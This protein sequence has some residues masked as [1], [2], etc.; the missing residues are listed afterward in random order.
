MVQ[1]GVMN[2]QPIHPHTWHLPWAPKRRPSRRRGAAACLQRHDQWCWHACGDASKRRKN[3]PAARPTRCST[4]TAQTLRFV[5]AICSERGPSVPLRQRGSTHETP[6]YHEVLTVVE[7]PDIL[8][9]VFANK[10]GWIFQPRVSS[11]SVRSR[12]I[13]AEFAASSLIPCVLLNNSPTTTWSS[14]VSSGNSAYTRLLDGDREWL[15]LT[16]ITWLLALGHHQAHHEAHG[17]QLFFCAV[18][19][20]RRGNIALITTLSVPDWQDSGHILDC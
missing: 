4:I 15:L 14:P 2:P 12:T 10:H 18:R 13:A 9:G 6:P 17:C 7:H 11:S 5:L 20:R 19:Q 3:S 8:D 1:S 16:S